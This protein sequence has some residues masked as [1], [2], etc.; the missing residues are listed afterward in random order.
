M[1]FPQKGG[2]RGA[3]GSPLGGPGV[4]HFQR[5]FQT[6]PLEFFLPAPGSTPLGLWTAGPVHTALGPRGGLGEFEGPGGGTGRGTDLHQKFEIPFAGAIWARPPG[7]GP[8]FVPGIGEAPAQATLRAWYGRAG[9][10]A[11]SSHRLR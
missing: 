8:S 9:G 4:G 3:A 10:P 7:A 11:P 1:V 6:G 5:S 2:P